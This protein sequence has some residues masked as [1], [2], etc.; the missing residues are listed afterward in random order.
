MKIAKIVASAL[1]LGLLAAP[2]AQAEVKLPSI[3]GDNMVLQAGTQVPIWGT[4]DPGAKIEVRVSSAV[5]KNDQ[6]NKTKD[7]N[8]PVSPM[9]VQTLTTTADEDGNWQVTLKPLQ[10]TSEAVGFVVTGKNKIS[11]K[12]VIVGDVWLCSGQSNMEWPVKRSKNAKE[13]IANAS[14]PEI[15]LFHT[16]R[17]TAVAGPQDDLEGEWVV[18]SPKTVPGFSGV[19]Y[20]FGLSLHKYTQ[21]PVGLIESAWGGTP[22]EA[23]TSRQ[24]LESLESV[25]SLLD[26]WAA[27]DKKDPKLTKNP[28]HPAVLYNAMIAPLIPYAIKGAIWYQGA[29]NASRAEQYRTLFSAMITDWRQQWDQGNFPFVFVQLANWR[30]RAKQPGPSDWAELREAQSLALELPHTAQAVII[31]LG[32][33]K[34]I[35]PK[36]KQDVGK[37]LAL[38]AQHAAYGEK[39][40][41]YSG[42]VLTSAKFEN[43]KAILTFTHIGSGLKAK[44]GELKSFAIAGDD[45]KFVWADAKIKGNQVIVSSEKVAQPVAVRYAWADNPAATLYNAEGLPASPFRTDNW[46]TK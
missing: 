19:G 22:A 38:A 44:G 41:V 11:L 18:C 3:I 17:A 29:S 39:D 40:V 16:K 28:H 10:A 13:E 36:N 45:Q 12:N 9:L 35:H 43:G 24:T 6:G 30:A 21:K 34:N 25:Q 32:E 46:P 20:F 8:Q 42:P 26:S 2:L 15:R 14:H 33:A 37:R 27:R 5:D 7:P 1:A 4:A 23:W 31:D